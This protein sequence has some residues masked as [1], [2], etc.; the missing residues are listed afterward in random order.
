MPDRGGNGTYELLHATPM[1]CQLRYAVRSVRACDIP[2]LN[3]ISLISKCNLFVNKDTRVCSFIIFVQHPVDNI[4]YVIPLRFACT[5]I[6][7]FFIDNVKCQRGTL[8]ER[9]FN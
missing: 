4:R 2:E 5:C 8:N 3:L 9:K 6:N 7:I 1:L